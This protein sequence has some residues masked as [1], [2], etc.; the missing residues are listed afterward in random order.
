MYTKGNK[1]LRYRRDTELQGGLVMP[2]MEDWNWEIIFTDIIGLSSTTMAVIGRQSNRIQ[3]KT[4]NKGYYAA[5]GHSSSSISVLIE[6]PYATS[7]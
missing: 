3:W 6:S 1:T 5:Q 2:N 4:Q 7:C